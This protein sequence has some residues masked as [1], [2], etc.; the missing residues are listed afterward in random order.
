MKFLFI[1]QTP[2]E[3][4][5]AIAKTAL[6]AMQDHA[7]EASYILFQSPTQIKASDID[8]I[9]GL[10]LGTLENIGALS[11]LTKDMFDRCYNDWLDRKQGLPVAFYIRAGLDGTATSRTLNSYAKALSWR[12]IAPP[13]ILHGSYDD[14]MPSD[15]A[16]LA[17]GLI[18]GVEAGIF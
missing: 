5:K 8:D 4:T 9:D 3:N 11:G 6:A 12:L 18:A 2:S 16:A 13:L 17:A 1:A 10:I 7:S 14:Q 15:A